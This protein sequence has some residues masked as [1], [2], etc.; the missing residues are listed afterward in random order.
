MVSENFLLPLEKV[1][2]AVEQTLKLAGFK[3]I[4]AD[5][6]NGTIKAVPGPGCAYRFDHLKTKVS[7][8]NFKHTKL[9]LACS[10]NMALGLPN[11]FRKLD[12]EGARL[13]GEI[14][15]HLKMTLPEHKHS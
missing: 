2:K 10:A 9:L 1:F 6:S 15:E 13:M 12:Q 14:K 4:V 7:T 8:E 3:I 11:P 5:Q